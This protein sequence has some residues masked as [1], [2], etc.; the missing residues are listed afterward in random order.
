MLTS[1]KKHLRD[2]NDT[3]RS[4]FVIEILHSRKEVNLV[5]YSPLRYPGGKSKIA[6]LIRLIMEKAEE[7]RDIYIEPFA[8]GA[9]VALSLLIEGTVDQIVI[10]DYDKAV[11]SFLCRQPTA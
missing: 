7:S 4:E 2:S 9:G 6:P 3:L 1:L 8:G 10:N 11:Y 5:N